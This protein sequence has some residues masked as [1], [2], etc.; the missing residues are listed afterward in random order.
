MQKLFS[1]LLL[2]CLFLHLPVIAKVDIQKSN[3]FP[4]VKMETSMGDVIIELNRRK[5]PITVDNFLTYAVNGEYNNTIFHRVVPAFVVQGGGYDKNFNEKEKGEGIFNESGNGLTN[6]YMTIAMARM[7]DP[8]SAVRQF[9]FNMADNKNLN[10]GRDW[11]YT[12]FGYVESG[13]DVLEKIAAV[14]TDFN[15]TLNATDVPVEP[16]LLKSVTLLPRP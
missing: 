6:D 8:H 5:A 9:F 3:L 12:V 11:G 15:E 1:R 10:P 16:V 13:Q 4:R 14:K 7:S 2:I